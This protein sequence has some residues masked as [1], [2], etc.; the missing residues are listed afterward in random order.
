MVAKQSPSK[1]KVTRCCI[2]HREPVGDTF[3]RAVCPRCDAMAF[4]DAASPAAGGR[5]GE[6][7]DNP[8]FIDGR[9]C[10]RYYSGD[11]WVTMLDTDN[12]RDFFDF[13]KQNRLPC[14]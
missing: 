7:G 1:D 13:C 3:P 14:D 8:V 4:N 2:C 6:P 12:C 10:W 5:A 11:G 9:Q